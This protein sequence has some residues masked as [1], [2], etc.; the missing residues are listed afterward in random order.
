MQGRGTARG[1]NVLNSPSGLFPSCATPDPCSVGAAWHSR[2]GADEHHAGKGAT[3]SP[4]PLC[5]PRGSPCMKRGWAQGDEG[6]SPPAFL[7][8]NLNVPK[9]VKLGDRARHVEKDF[10]LLYQQERSTGK[11]RP[12][13]AQMRWRQLS[14]PHVIATSPLSISRVLE[15]R[16][17]VAQPRARGDG[18][19]GCPGRQLR[20][21]RARAKRRSRASPRGAEPAPQVASCP[22]PAQREKLRLFWV[23]PQESH[24]GAQPQLRTGAGCEGDRQPGGKRRR[25]GK[26]P[27]WGTASASELLGWSP[28]LAGWH[29]GAGSLAAPHRRA[30]LK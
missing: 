18:S 13:S 19:P 4:A 28:R 15:G 27:G 16:L 23:F 20:R 6:C 29:G 3:L 26:R 24:G 8:F 7:A 2:R 1:P 11:G 21:W 22:S 10:P 9:D 5:L 14:L 30:R 17:D 12:A 25:A